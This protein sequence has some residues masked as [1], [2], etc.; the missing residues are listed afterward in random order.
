MAQGG[1]RQNRSEGLSAWWPSSSASVF[2]VVR[3]DLFQLFLSPE[4]L[5]PRSMGTSGVEGTFLGK[6]LKT[7][8]V[9][10]ELGCES[11]S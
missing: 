5:V 3:G 11:S 1:Q 2:W 6:L 9:N 4:P 8:V 7:T 10:S